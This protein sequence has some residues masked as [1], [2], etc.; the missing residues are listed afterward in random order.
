[1]FALLFSV[2]LFYVVAM[3][4]GAYDGFCL[5][6]QHAG[7]DLHCGDDFNCKCKALS[8]ILVFGFY[9]VYLL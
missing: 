6:G 5:A 1:M 8:C 3:F 4:A 9:F 7:R 2:Y